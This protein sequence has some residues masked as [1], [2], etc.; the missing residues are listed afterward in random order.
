MV[1]KCKSLLLYWEL[2]FIWFSFIMFDLEC[3]YVLFDCVVDLVD[4]GVL[5]II[6][7]EYYGCINVVNLCCVYVLIESYCV[8]GKLVFEGF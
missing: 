6:F 5:C 4:V 1:F 3:Q 2:M 8:C 7:G